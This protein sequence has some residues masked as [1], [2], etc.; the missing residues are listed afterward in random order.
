[1]N[2]D[3]F[4]VSF[5]SENDGAWQPS[6]SRANGRYDGP[7]AVGRRLFVEHVQPDGMYEEEED[8]S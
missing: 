3:P 8:L 4:T 1:M 5:V 7:G 6:A 2:G